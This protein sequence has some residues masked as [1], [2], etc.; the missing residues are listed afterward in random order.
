VGSEERLAVWATM[1]A[2]VGQECL[3]WDAGTVCFR[4][5]SGERESIRPSQERL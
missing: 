2:A 5:Q 1:V 4:T 3:P